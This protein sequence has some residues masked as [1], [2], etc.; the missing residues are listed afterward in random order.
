MK[1][2]ILAAALLL[3][4]SAVR[5][6]TDIN[7]DISDEKKKYSVSIGS[8]GIKAGKKADGK[9]EESQFELQYGMVDL[10]YNRIH[11]RG[12]Q[13]PIVA[14]GDPKTHSATWG[15]EGPYDYLPLRESKSV[16]VNVYPVMA[17]LRLSA[18]KRE[19]QNFYLTTGVGLQMYN[20]RFDDVY[21]FTDEPTVR[22]E[23]YS[24][25]NL[26]KNKLGFT[27]LSV[28]LGILGKTRL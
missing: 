6:Q 7:V 3:T 16:N 12:E 28:P 15:I 13:S 11:D 8:D 26:R 25:L 18:V 10:G 17:K 14:F 27:F 2:I 5:S 4:T 20:F 24:S 23:D 19:V 1:H 9:K 21:N 22:L